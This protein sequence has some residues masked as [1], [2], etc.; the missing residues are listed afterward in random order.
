[1]TFNDNVQRG[2]TESQTPCVT[3]ND[4]VQRGRTESQT[5]CVTFNDNVQRGRI[6]SQ[7]PCVTHNDNVPRGR[8][9]SQ[10]PCVTHNDNLQRGRIES[11]TPRVRSLDGTKALTKPHCNHNIRNDTYAGTTECQRDLALLSWVP[12]THLRRKGS[13]S[14]KKL[15]EPSREQKQLYPCILADH[16]DQL[17]VTIRFAEQNNVNHNPNMLE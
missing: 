10:T 17:I 13:N 3:H 16:S 9:E 12:G 1:M 6:E 5:P 11:R 8:I 2:R 7:T 4:N 15:Q 14:G